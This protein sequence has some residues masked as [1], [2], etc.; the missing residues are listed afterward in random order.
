MH[1][2]I[3][4][5]VITNL[6]CEVCHSGSPLV[7]EDSHHPALNITFQ[8]T[9]NKNRDPNS[10]SINNL[11]MRY[12]FRKA[13]FLLLYNLLLEVDWSFLPE[14]SEHSITKYTTFLT[15][16]FQKSII[17]EANSNITTQSGTVKL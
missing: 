15:N 13:N 17:I 8:L 3:I 4:D 16:A 9:V 7:P 2:N 1:H 6:N 11:Q 14:I 12:N 10:F 5:L